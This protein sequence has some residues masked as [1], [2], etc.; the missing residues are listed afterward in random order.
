[1]QA[2]S[3]KTP[4]TR[5]TTI[6]T[7]SMTICP[8]RQTRKVGAEKEIP[9]A[10]R[11][12]RQF[13]FRATLRMGLC[14]KGPASKKNAP[15]R[16]GPGAGAFPSFR[17]S[18]LR[19]LREIIAEHFAVENIASGIRRIYANLTLIFATSSALTGTPAQGTEGA[20]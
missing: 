6:R 7:Q 2:R 11:R 16:G 18:R 14:G 12:S 4:H 19:G 13:H 9:E 17:V 3:S 20:N 15:P 10:W 5:E 8:E 1:M